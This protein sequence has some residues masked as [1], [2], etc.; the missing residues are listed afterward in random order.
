[1]EKIRIE[2]TSWTL[3][4]YHVLDNDRKSYEHLIFW[5]IWNDSCNGF[6]H[7]FGSAENFASAPLQPLC[8]SGLHIVMWMQKGRKW[9]LGEIECLQILKVQLKWHILSHSASL[10]TQYLH[11]YVRNKMS[12]NNEIQRESEHNFAFPT[13]WQKCTYDLLAFS[14]QYSLSLVAFTKR[15]EGSSYSLGQRPYNL[16][17]LSTLKSF[18]TAKAHHFTKTWWIILL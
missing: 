11:F 12:K 16:I 7:Y 14:R 9:H 17:I 18:L 5:K 8:D 6:L 4:W 15:N 2:T 3:D 1:M 10:N 13:K